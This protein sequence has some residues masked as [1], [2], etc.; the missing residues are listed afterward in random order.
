MKLQ[1]YL[2]W[3]LGKKLLNYMYTHM[4]V[5]MIFQDFL[6]MTILRLSILF[7][8]KKSCLFTGCLTGIG[9]VLASCTFL[10]LQ[11]SVMGA[12]IIPQIRLMKIHWLVCRGFMHL[13]ATATLQKVSALVPS[14]WT[15]PLVLLIYL[16]IYFNYYYYFLSFLF[17]LF[18]LFD[19]W[20]YVT[21]SF[22]EAFCLYE[23][24]IHL[25]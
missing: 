3:V 6:F 24:T 9:S 23:V 8:L 5:T 22:S 13:G 15:F 20:Q 18:V 21:V 14:F 4:Y 19:W 25:L 1:T 16:Y 2:S 17:E 7:L 11:L 10:A 12:G